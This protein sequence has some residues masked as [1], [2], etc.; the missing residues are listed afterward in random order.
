MQAKEMTL[1]RLLEGEKQYRVPLYQRPYSWGREQLDQLSSDILNQANVIQDGGS[2]PGHFLGSVVL[3]P[4]PRNAAGSAQ[5]WIVVDGQQ[6]LTTLLVAL[7]AVRDHVRAEDAAAAERIQKQSLVNEYLPDPERLKLVPTQVDRD[8]F[9]RIIDSPQHVSGGNLAAAY[10]FFVASLQAA[11]DPEDPH[12]IN[13]IEQAIRGHLDIVAI[14]TEAD[15]NVHRIFESLNNTGMGLTQGDLLRNYLFMLLPT[16]AEHVYGSVWQPMQE[17]IGSEH[18]ETLAYLDLQLRGHAGIHRSDTHRV[19]QERFRGIEQDEQAVEA[20]IRELARRARHLKV[21]LDPTSAPDTG[22]AAT[23][24]RL[25]EWG[26]EATYPVVMAVLDRYERGAGSI[27]EITDTGLCLESYLVRRM[28]CGRSAAGL[29]RTLANAATHLMSASDAAAGLREY[30][31]QPRRYWPDDE[32]LAAG[33]AERNFYWSGKAA[34]RRFVLRRLEESYEHKE[35]LDWSNSRIQIEHVMPQTP[36]AEWLRSLDADT[37]PGETAEELHQSLVQRLGNLTLTAYNPELGND[38]FEQKR[39]RYAESHFELAKEVAAEQTW[40]RNQITERGAELAR[41]AATIW[42]GPRGMHQQPPPDQWRVLRQ[43]LVALPQGTWTSYGDLAGVIGIP[44]RP[45]GNYLSTTPTPNAWRVLRSDGSVS[46]NF[47]WTD[48]ARTDDPRDVLASEGVRIDRN[49]GTADPAQRLSAI[50]LAELLGL[51][52]SEDDGEP[53]GDR[54]SKESL[55]YTQLRANQPA[56]VC[57]AVAAMLADWTARGGTLDWGSSAQVSVAP[58]VKDSTGRERW[59]WLLCPAQGLIEVVFQYLKVR[60]PFDD[61]ATR[62]ALR[63]AI[64]E[65]PGVDLAAARL[66]LR[67]SFPMRHIATSEGSQAVRRVHEWFIAQL[68][69]TAVPAAATTFTA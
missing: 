54:I 67:P 47:C 60:P 12:D 4:A 3:A 55:F 62:E 30:L 23:V 34:Q 40:G 22:I 29:N 38:T 6:R 10:R 50:E 46:P 1:V 28:L 63:L 18:I 52:V 69:D 65:I 42:P 32:Q 26:A 68:R 36:T 15:D 57:D 66:E 44:A 48:P 20:E 19:Q 14:T 7:A 5:G 41:R 43:V 37:E 33:I 16:R 58:V 61:T 59:P 51:D 21:I 24:Q 17:L 11:D 64:N 2:G 49:T 27:K 39:K 35:T 31:S 53:T 45:I 56:D 9:T 13:R 8:A 25:N